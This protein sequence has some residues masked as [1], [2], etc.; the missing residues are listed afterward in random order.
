MTNLW[1]IFLIG[2]WIAIEDR[3]NEDRWD[4]ALIYLFVLLCHIRYENF[5]YAL[6]LAFYAPRLLK[7][8]DHLL[9]GLI[10]LTP[11][12]WQAYVAIGNMENGEEALLD[13]LR[14]GRRSW[15]FIKGLTDPMLTYPYALMTTVLIAAAVL[16]WAWKRQNPLTRPAKRTLL[17][18]GASTVLYFLITSSHFLA[19]PIHPSVSRLYMLPAITIIALAIP[20]FMLLPRRLQLMAAGAAACSWIFTQSIAIEKKQTRS[21]SLIRATEKIYRFIEENY[22]RSDVIITDRPGQ[23]TV[24]PMG[25]VSHDWAQVNLERLKFGQRRGVYP[26]VYL[27][28]YYDPNQGRKHPLIDSAKHHSLLI[29]V[30]FDERQNLALVSLVW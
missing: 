18:V 21:L 8:V 7:R 12:L 5:I 9:F 22:D 14:I 19:D 17:F 15:N 23:Y 3:V 10:L 28:F 1:G 24:F 6:P 16:F 27:A 4:V 2:F 20:G 13:P 25:A 30:P 11:R 29:D 26:H